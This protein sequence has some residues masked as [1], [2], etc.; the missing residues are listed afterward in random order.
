ME[1]S[2]IFEDKIVFEEETKV[3]LKKD[4]LGRESKKEMKVKVPKHIRIP[5]K[6]IQIPTQKEVS[7]FKTKIRMEMNLILSQYVVNKLPNPYPLPALI[8]SASSKEQALFAKE[9]F[10]RI[11]V[12]QAKDHGNHW[13]KLGWALTELR[14]TQ[15]PQ[16]SDCLRKV[17]QEYHN[18]AEGAKCISQKIS[19]DERRNQMCW[20][21]KEYVKATL[22]QL[23]SSGNFDL[24]SE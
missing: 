16:N 17:L 13:M 14:Q 6:R 9:V 5:K 18:D 11:L 2:T 1:E 24:L 23:P 8:I 12:N 21:D 10:K 19:D 22:A 7:R 15:I 3:V 20:N 4:W